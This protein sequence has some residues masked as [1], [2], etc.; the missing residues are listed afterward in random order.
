VGALGNNYAWYRVQ[1]PSGNREFVVERGTTNLL[2]AMAY[3]AAAKFTT[4]GT[5]AAAPTASDGVAIFGDIHSSTGS[6]GTYTQFLNTDGQYIMHMGASD[7][8]TQYMFYVYTQQL[9]GGGTSPFSFWCMDYVTVPDT[10]DL[11]PVVHYANQASQTPLSI[12]T[13]QNAKAMFGPS[14]SA[15]NFTTCGLSGWAGVLGSNGWSPYEDV[16]PPTAYANTG[17]KGWKGFSSLF[18]FLGSWSSGAHYPGDVVSIGNPPVIGTK[19]WLCLNSG[20]IIPWPPGT[21]PI[22]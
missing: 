2:W 19:N 18:R 12:T 1:D 21:D 13:G 7:V 22:V 6:S 5:S 16:S 9:A 10:G 11:D 14:V 3:S 15:A 8:T 17:T 20:I 4:G